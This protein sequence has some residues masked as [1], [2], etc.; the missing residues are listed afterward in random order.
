MGGKVA[1]HLAK[2]FG[3]PTFDI[4]IL[5]LGEDDCF[6]LPKGYRAQPGPAFASCAIAGHPWDSTEGELRRLINADT[7]T[8]LVIFDNWVLNC[9]RHPPDL[10]VR[11]P[12]YGNV[13]LAE[14]GATGRLRL[15]AMDHTHCFNCGREWSAALAHDRWMKDERTYGLF[16]Q[17][18]QFLS[19]TAGDAAVSRLR[20]MTKELA[21]AVV[22]PIPPEWEVTPVATDALIELIYRRASLVA[23]GSCRNCP[24]DWP[25]ERIRMPYSE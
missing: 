24:L 8:R 2:W 22:P 25:L 10:M 18:V 7:I 1:T 14:T 5:H 12:N 3:L 6:A 9:D 20:E 4:A 19:R 11:H 17:F 21:I 23:I 13:F 15:M 16:P